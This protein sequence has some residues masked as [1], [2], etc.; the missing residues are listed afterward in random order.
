MTTYCVSCV[1]YYLH[2]KTL[3][4]FWLSPPVMIK[5]I[6]GGTCSIRTVLASLSSV[7]KP[8]KKCY[9]I[10]SLGLSLLTSIIK[11][12]LIQLIN[13]IRMEKFLQTPSWRLQN[14]RPTKMGTFCHVHQNQRPLKGVSGQVSLFLVGRPFWS[15]QNEIS[16]IFP[17]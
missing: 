10:A 5:V 14:E 17:M 12:K 3:K 11:I 4:N 2:V 9:I 1:W 13:I 6:N 7:I 15:L 8:V 16:K